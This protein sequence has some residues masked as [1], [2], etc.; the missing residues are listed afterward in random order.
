[1]IWLMRACAA[2]LHVLK[3][4]RVL[5]DVENIVALPNEAAE[6]EEML[7][8]DSQLLQVKQ[9]CFACC[10]HARFGTVTSSLPGMHCCKE[11][12]VHHQ[13]VLCKHLQA[14]T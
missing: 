3:H 7:K 2:V 12:I 14:H 11:L 4:A 6:A 1:M 8:D 10:M 13:L 9:T 5:Q